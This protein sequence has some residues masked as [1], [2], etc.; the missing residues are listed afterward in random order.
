[1]Q[2]IEGK[3]WKRCLDSDGEVVCGLTLIRIILVITFSK[4][5]P[6]FSLL[7]VRLCFLL[8]LHQEIVVSCAGNGGQRY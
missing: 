8:G 7:F 3:G 1:M 2:E 4:D 6:Y 5:N